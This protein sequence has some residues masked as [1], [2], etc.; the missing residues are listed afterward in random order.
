MKTQRT[1]NSVSAWDT[2]PAWAVDKDTL[3]F[4]LGQCQRGEDETH[5]T[6]EVVDRG[7]G[8]KGGSRRGLKLFRKKLMRKLVWCER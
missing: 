5:G 8:L 1:A 7:N 3:C 6:V 2:F 4:G